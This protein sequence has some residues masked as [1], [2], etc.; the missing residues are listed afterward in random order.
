MTGDLVI[1]R[2][3][4]GNADVESRLTIEGSRPSSQHAAATI[5]FINDQTNDTGFLTYRSG[6][7]GNWFAF[8]QDVDLNNNGGCRQRKS[9]RHADR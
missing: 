5:K 3:T 6:S 2:T 8:N 9:P 7:G 4:D 1:D